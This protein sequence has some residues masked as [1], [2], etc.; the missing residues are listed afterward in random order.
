MIWLALVALAGDAVI[1]GRTEDSE[2]VITTASRCAGAIHS[3]TWRGKEFLD[4][5]DHGRQLQA[6]SNL[7]LGTAITS[8]TFNP[9][10]AGSRRDG[11]GERSSSLLL[12][13]RAR[14]NSLTTESKMAFWLAPG[15][16]SGGN[17]AKN[18]TVVSEH[19]LRK[20]VT[21]GVRG[22]AHL[23]GYDVTFTL[24]KNEKHGQ[25]VF[26]SLTGYMPSE[27]RRFWRYDRATRALLPLSDG[28]GEQGDPVVLATD[29]GAYAMGIYSP[30]RTAKGY[31]R[32]RFVPEQVVKWNC[33]FRVTDPVPGRAYRYRHFVAVGTLEQVR[34][35]LERLSGERG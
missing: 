6:A 5:Y 29:D 11:T 21:I 13:L 30:E 33:V 9:T 31:G 19:R 3:L 26:E 34:Q 12:A 8:E 2:I 15:E 1:R 28:P 24:P 25:A 14:R 10:E 20:S 7:D 17:L 4:S 27:F 16:D 22:R 18:T 35:E 23:I 32:W